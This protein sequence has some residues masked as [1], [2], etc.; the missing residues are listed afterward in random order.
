MLTYLQ[1]M[2]SFDL[3]RRKDLVY[4]LLSAFMLM[5]IGGVFSRSLDFGLF[6]IAFILIALAMLAIYQLQ[7]ASENAAVHGSASAVVR[8]A[9]KLALMLALGFPVFFLAVPRYQTHELSNLPISGRLRETVSKFSGG[10]MYP[11]QPGSASVVDMPFGGA[12]EQQYISS[13][14]G[15]FGFVSNFDLNNRGRLTDE[16][17][18]RV[19]TPRAVYHRGL[20]FDTFTGTGWSISDLDGT[21]V[22]AA[23]RYSMFD[24]TKSGEAGY[25]SAYIDNATVYTSYY[26]ESDMPNM[27]YAPYRPDMIYFPVSQLVLDKNLSVRVPALLL[28]GT[29]YTVVSSIPASDPAALSRVPARPCPEAENDYCSGAFITPRIRALAHF[30][31]DGSPSLLVKMAKI[32]NYLVENYTYDV[33]APVAPRGRNAVD[34]FLF[35]SKR[36]FCEHFASAMAVLARA[37]DVPSRVVTGFAPGQ[38]NPF[39]GFFEVRGTDA[40]AWT[41][42]YFP[43]AGWITFDPT[44]GASGGPVLMK[45]TTPF[46]FFL[47]T[48]FNKIGI[49]AV[50][51]WNKMHLRFGGV[52]IDT[53]GFAL[54]VFIALI[55]LLMIFKKGIFREAG[56]KNDP[57]RLSGA[58]REIA[59]L[60]YGLFKRSD[61]P[62]SSAAGELESVFPEP[63]RDKYRRFADIYNRAAFSGDAATVVEL[64]EARALINELIKMK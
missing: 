57:D 9:A 22:V 2:H 28:K 41:E 55:A 61:A 46:T 43:I 42:I 52:A 20:V 16:V 56:A 11:R 29:V 36:G 14:G 37:V 38:Y 54:G 3:P 33:D 4:S 44:P 10:L 13:G 51:A 35:D 7:E 19:R 12:A 31:T 64:R 45:E 15:Y 32:E 8:G 6:L 30:I 48:Y 49:A 60:M 50:S 63:A 24:L 26:L 47:D 1:V 23:G 39:T 59:R 40:H 21:H 27:I 53:F 58:N 18:M 5:C 62:K 34:F 17:V 25:R